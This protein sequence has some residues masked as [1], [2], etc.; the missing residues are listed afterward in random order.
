MTKRGHC[1][2]KECPNQFDEMIGGEQAFGKR[3]VGDCIPCLIAAQLVDVG[4][5][6]DLIEGNPQMLEMTA[7]HLENTGW[8]WADLVASYGRKPVIF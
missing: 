5:G 3:L 2:Q 7:A 6:L 8:T 4:K 1:R